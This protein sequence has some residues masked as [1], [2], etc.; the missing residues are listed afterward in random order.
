MATNLTHLTNGPPI[1][2]PLAAAVLNRD[3][4][5][6]AALLAGG[7]DAD[8]NQ[9]IGRLARG[10]TPLHCVCHDGHTEGVTV[11]LAAGA[12]VNQASDD[13]CTP[14]YVACQRGHTEV[15]TKLI[16]ANAD[17]NQAREAGATPLYIACVNGH[18]DVVTTLLAANTDVNQA[19]N[20]GFTPLFIACYHGHLGCVQLLS[21]YSASR[22]FTINGNDTTAETVATAAGHFDIANWLSRSRRWSELH[23]LKVLTPERTLALLR[24]DFE[25]IHR[26]AGP[27]GPTPL[28]I[29]DALAA[30]GEAAE[31][32]AA[33]LVLQAAKP[34]SRKTHKYFPA[35]A[36]ARAVEL[37]PWGF[38][39]S[40]QFPREEQAMFDV[41][42]TIV[43]PME[44]T[45]AYTRPGPQRA[46]LKVT[47][48][49]FDAA[50]GRVTV[51]LPDGQA[52]SVD[53]TS[54]K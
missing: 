21:S 15:V 46:L 28:W 33:F 3:M 9:P 34:W 47:T 53:A 24:D 17:V 6:V 44:V 14:L 42:M 26:A 19:K 49:A 29:A 25:D 11:L 13:G 35:A 4:A 27:G 43:M 16:E 51:H 48:G 12:N 36:R 54:L 45:R 18:T 10:V 1:S 30:K 37:W 41:W 52:I 38:R 31:G 20:N 50:T 2:T 39:F 5:R 22:T 8:V 23:H 32:T 7:A 40:R